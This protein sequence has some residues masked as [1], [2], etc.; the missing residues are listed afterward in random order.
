M[1]YSKYLVAIT[2]VLIGVITVFPI[3]IKPLYIIALALTPVVIRFFF[4]NFELSVI[5]LLIIRSA[6]DPFTEKGLTGAFA[7][8]LSGLTL[9]YIIVRLLSKKKVQVDSFFCFFA[10]WI[11]LQGLW[12][13][14]LPLGGLG[15]DGEHISDAI[16]EW[17]RIFSWLMAYLLTLQLKERVSPE[18]F[19][20][21]LLLA[22]AIP[23]GVAF[24]QLLVPDRLLPTFLAINRNQE[25]LRINGTLGVANTF[26]TFLVFFTGLTYWKLNNSQKRLPWILLLIVLTFFVVNTKTLVGI[27]MLVVL[28]TSLIIP[29]LSFT[30]LIGSTLL[31]ALILG[32]FLSTDFGQARLESIAQTPLLNPDIDVSR[33][34]LL[35]YQDSNSFNWRIAQWTALLNHWK[36]FQV[37]G[38]GLQMTNYLGPMFAWAHND[39]IRVLVEE[40]VVGFSLFL[41]FLGTQL[42]RLFKLIVSPLTVKSQ[43]LFCLILFANMLA[44]MVGMLTE[45]IWSH[46]ALFF[47]WFSMSAIADWKWGNQ[48]E[49]IG[50][51]TETKMRLAHFG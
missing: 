45:N 10:I 42:L 21:Y 51:E 9:I 44:I 22:L 43:K 12:V 2:G 31:I 39:Y 1:I 36:F 32:I 28:I 7:I 27:T 15:F 5:G 35:S 23:L 13:V 19:I 4:N 30:N 40:G 17:V 26:A 48:E 50:S 33:A 41:G 47:Y 37:F 38:Y 11:I 18:K 29:R 20:N 6:L 34:V 25:S 24:L 46:T 8:G 14:L 3:G 49:K 16:R